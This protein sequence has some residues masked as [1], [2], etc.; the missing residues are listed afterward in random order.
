MQL[1]SPGS[2]MSKHE[3][4]VTCTFFSTVVIRCVTISH[5]FLTAQPISSAAISPDPDHALLTGRRGHWD[6]EMWKYATFSEVYC[7]LLTT[8]S[9]PF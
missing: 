3:T 5:R 4:F 6:V 1:F 7:I 2:F 9:A 8:R